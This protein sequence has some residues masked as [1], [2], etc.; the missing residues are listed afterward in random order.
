MFAAFAFGVPPMRRRLLDVRRIQRFDP[1]GR[2]AGGRERGCRSGC[3]RR[4]GRRGRDGRHFD[5][6]RSACPAR[7]ATRRRPQHQARGDDSEQHDRAEEAGQGARHR[8][9]WVMRNLRGFFRLTHGRSWR[10]SFSE[11]RRY[12]QSSKLI[13]FG[14][15]AQRE[16]RA[17][18]C[19]RSEISIAHRARMPASA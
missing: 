3:A 13:E 15:R 5:R 11:R 12:L 14:S 18:A 16:S 6:R 4:G 2:G 10:R 19:P 9:A 7:R 8:L 17:H 1:I